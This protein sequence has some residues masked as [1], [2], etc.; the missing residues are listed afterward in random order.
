MVVVMVEGKNVTI[1]MVVVIVAMAGL[2]R[3]SLDS[4][5][6]RRVDDDMDAGR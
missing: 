4:A 2:S 3:G 1:V 6:Y 5:S